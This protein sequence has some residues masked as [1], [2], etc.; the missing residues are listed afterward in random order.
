MVAGLAYDFHG[1]A[2]SSMGVDAGDYDGDGR[3][4][5]FATCYQSE[6]PVLYHNL[7]D[8]FY[9]DATSSAKIDGD[10]FAHVHWGTGFID[11]DND[12][13]QDLFVACGHFDPIELI[14]DRTAKNVRNYLL[15][16]L[17]QGTFT[18]VSARCGSGMSVVASSRGAAFGDLDNDGDVDAVIV[19]SGAVPNGDSQRLAG[20]EPLAA[21]PAAASRRKIALPVVCVYGSRRAKNRRSASPS[22]GVDTRVTL[23][24][25]SILDS[26]NIPR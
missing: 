1:N 13:D 25:T 8:G 14:D 23:G 3:L 18:D 16:N 10:L 12:A 21:D 2:N 15:M 6:M 24:P 26:A 9:E 5:L 20:R 19:N 17:G 11:F 4:D 22:A 7:G